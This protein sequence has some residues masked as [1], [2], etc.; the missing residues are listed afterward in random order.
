MA[1]PGA[2]LQS[3]SGATSPPYPRDIPGLLFPAGGRPKRQRRSCSPNGDEGAGAA[4]NER[5]AARV[6]WRSTAGRPPGRDGGCI[7]RGVALG[8]RWRSVLILLDGGSG[9]ATA[10]LP[11]RSS[12]RRRRRGPDC[13]SCGT[14]GCS[15]AVSALGGN[16]GCEDRGG[17]GFEQVVAVLSGELKRALGV[18]AVAL[19]AVGERFGPAEVCARGP[20]R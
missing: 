7:H 9:V 1:P 16:R 10:G 12:S 17:A 20:H 4:G 19:A 8:R 5:V 2:V 14:G 15:C 18:C 13:G 11:D 6:R 3:R